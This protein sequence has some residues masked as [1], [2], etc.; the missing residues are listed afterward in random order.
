MHPKTCSWLIQCLKKHPHKKIGSN[1]QVS[2][3]LYDI[4]WS[5]E[6]GLSSNIL[7]RG[8]CVQLDRQLY[9]LNSISSSVYL[10]HRSFFSGEL[11]LQCVPSANVSIWLIVCKKSLSRFAIK[12]L[13]LCFRKK[14]SFCSI[15]NFVYPLSVHHS[16]ESCN[17][18]DW[19]KKTNSNPNFYVQDPDMEFVKSFTPPDLQAKNFT[20]S[21]SPNFN[22]FSDK[23]TKK[24]VKMEKF[25]PL[26]KIL[27]C[28]RQWRHWQIPTLLLFCFTFTLIKF[29]CYNANTCCWRQVCS[30]S[31][32]QW[33]SFAV[34]CVGLCDSVNT[35]LWN[36][37]QLPKDVCLI[38]ARSMILRV[39]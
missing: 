6:L 21:I 32:S 22:S 12:I 31:C 28:H 27:H 7:S 39:L 23:N 4:F 35:Q 2:F 38:Y 8:V 26:A 30:A 34:S 29:C 10:A 14:L 24:W 33:S 16:L 15:K 3:I 11:L 5:A 9:Y 37:E 13:Q 19:L 1:R 25:T 17:Y 36:G 18:F 20:P